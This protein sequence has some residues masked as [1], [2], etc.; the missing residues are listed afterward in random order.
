MNWILKV[1]TS[2]HEV[3]YTWSYYSN[4]KDNYDNF[5]FSY[6]SNMK[7][8]EP[9]GHKKFKEAIQWWNIECGSEIVFKLSNLWAKN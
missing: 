6:S 3:D 4:K 8:Y 2:N 9:S 5:L 7:D 1:R